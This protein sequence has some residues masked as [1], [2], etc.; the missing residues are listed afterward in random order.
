MFALSS[1]RLLA[2]LVFL[3]AGSLSLAANAVDRIELR[4]GSVLLGTFKDADGGKV[5]FDT[6]FAG[7][8][9]VDQAEIVA[10]TVE[11]DLVLQMEDGEVLQAP[12]LKVDGERLQLEQDAERSY[13]LAQ[14]TRINPEPWE[15]GNGYHFTGLASLAFNS[16]RGNTEV[17]ELN[18][19]ILT[20][21]ESLRDRFRVEGFGEVNEARGVK[22]AENW[23][24]RGR[25]DRLQT[26][27][28][29]W[30]GGASAEQ[31]LF[32]DLDL[33]TS[34]GPYI[35][36]KF[37]TDPVFELEAE[38]GLAY[39]TEDF[40]SGVDRDYLGSTWDVHIQSNYLG[41]DSRLYLDHKG[42]W[43]LDE[44]E[45]IVLNTTVGIAF[46]LFGGIEG[47]AEVSWNLNTGAVAGT[48]ELD[49]AYRLRIGYAW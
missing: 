18:Y 31:D 30:G 22:N 11:S 21:W 4:D 9:E 45:N 1:R 3:C 12:S 24:L 33:R 8:L 17:D 16:Q 2:A 47:A 5:S 38:T 7:T 44:A 10:M 14:L 40:I 28:W 37:F 43:N 6:S 20:R 34:I 42:I 32:A 35:G 46:P 36:R 26:G 48:E 27:D 29:Y 15:L 23:T 49:E 25:Y 41:G 13:A 19:R 39:T